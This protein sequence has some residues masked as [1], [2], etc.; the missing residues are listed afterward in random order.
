M[1]EL[2]IENLFYL[3][4]KLQF[5]LYIKCFILVIVLYEYVNINVVCF[6]CNHK[7]VF[8]YCNYFF[9]IFYFVL[10]IIKTIYSNFI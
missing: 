9:K 7:N 2:I 1:C 10:N 4:L 5:S 3:N 6:I 8:K